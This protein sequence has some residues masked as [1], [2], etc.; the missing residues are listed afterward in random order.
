MTHAP[1]L[2]AAS[3]GFPK[4]QRPFGPSAAEKGFSRLCRGITGLE[5]SDKRVCQA[6]RGKGG[7]PL[8]K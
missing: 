6:K 3:A 5:R 8:E 1:S 2:T 7:S 4:G